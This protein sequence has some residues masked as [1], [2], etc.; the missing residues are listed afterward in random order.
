MISATRSWG[1]SRQSSFPGA[2]TEFS[3]LP[4]ALSLHLSIPFSCLA[5]PAVR[6][7]PPTTAITRK[8]TCTRA[9]SHSRTQHHPAPTLKAAPLFTL[10]VPAAACPFDD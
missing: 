8:A 7:H 6:N 1:V 4:H 9:R 3:L 2:D 5:V 10:D